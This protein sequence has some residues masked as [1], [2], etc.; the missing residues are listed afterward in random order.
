MQFRNNKMA[1]ANRRKAFI[2]TLGLFSFSV[3][4]CITGYVEGTED[5]LKFCI[6]RQQTP[7]P[8]KCPK[9]APAGMELLIAP[10]GSPSDFAVRAD[11]G[12]EEQSSISGS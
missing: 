7:S 12:V 8:A 9:Q 11:K 4:G 3:S 5:Y 10:T 6:E 1:K 2:L